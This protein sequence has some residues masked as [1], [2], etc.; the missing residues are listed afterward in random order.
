MADIFAGCIPFHHT[1]RSGGGVGFL[2]VAEGNVA[3]LCLALT[4]T[5]LQCLLSLCLLFEN[6]LQLHQPHVFLHLQSLMVDPL[7]IAMPW[8]VQAFSGFLEVRELLLLWDRM[9]GFDTLEVIA[10]LAASVFAYRRSALLAAQSARDV[11]L[12]LRD[13]IGL[14]V[15]T[16]LQFSLFAHQYKD[17]P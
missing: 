17:A 8:I 10:V 15:I 2:G 11:H 4:S 13:L 5:T 12:V 3:W 9:I 14:K 1:L 7:R 6:L 16:L